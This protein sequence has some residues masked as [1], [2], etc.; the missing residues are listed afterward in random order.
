MAAK[1]IV[2]TNRR[3]RYDYS[4]DDTIEAGIVLEGPEVKSLREGK[5]SIQEAYATVEDGELWLVDMHISPYSAADDKKL[6][7]RRRRK[8]LVHK[9]ELSRLAGQVSA[10][11]YTLIPLRVYFNERGYAKV[12]L[13]LARGKR[14]YDKREAIAEREYQR[15]IQRLLG[16]R[17]D[18]EG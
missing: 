7:P 17:A 13:G 4:I 15:R 8:L 12:E 2:A 10:K 14:K 3:A 5:C 16:R 11:G 6:D 1:K 18:M 9:R